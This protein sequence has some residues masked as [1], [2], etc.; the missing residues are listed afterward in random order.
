MLHSPA[1][2]T[3][4]LV[5]EKFLWAPFLVTCNFV[6]KVKFFSI[7]LLQAMLD[8]LRQTILV[9]PLLPLCGVYAV[10]LSYLRLAPV[11]AYWL[12]AAAG[13]DAAQLQ[14]RMAK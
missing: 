6:T 12:C 11:A 1:R 13:A 8:T 4:A 14:H 5:E 9:W 3:A 7:I 2:I 10:S